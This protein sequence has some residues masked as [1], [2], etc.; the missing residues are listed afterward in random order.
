MLCKKFEKLKGIKKI[1]KKLVKFDKLLIFFGF[2]FNAKN[3]NKVNKKT[4]DE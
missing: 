2:F 3:T 1:N 4:E